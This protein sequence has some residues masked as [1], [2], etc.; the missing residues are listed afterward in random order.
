MSCLICVRSGRF[1]CRNKETGKARG[2]C[3]LPASSGGNHDPPLRRKTLCKL[4]AGAGH[5]QHYKAARWQRRKQNVVLG[6]GQIRPH[7]IELRL[8]TVKRPMADQK[9]KKN[10]VWLKFRL[11]QCKCPFYIFCRAS[12]GLSFRTLFRH[13]PYLTC[14]QAETPS[15]PRT[16]L[17]VPFFQL[18]PLNTP[19]P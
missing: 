15:P 10:I 8:L 17:P 2:I 9:D 11:Q 7:E 16:Q 19:P 14:G 3:F 4:P 5:I 1:Q 6:S 13:K 12:Y 18:L